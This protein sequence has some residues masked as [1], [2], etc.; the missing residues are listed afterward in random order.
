MK[1]AQKAN[2]IVEYRF[3]RFMAQVSINLKPHII[4]QIDDARGPQSRSSFI[5][6]CIIEHFGPRGEAEA[7]Q[8]ARLESDVQ[9]LRLEN[10]KLIDAVSQRLLE[11]APKKS[12]WDRIRNR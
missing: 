4:K 12:L 2:F 9:Y 1:K 5:K 6:D 8:I 3:D 10:T 7:K 11:P